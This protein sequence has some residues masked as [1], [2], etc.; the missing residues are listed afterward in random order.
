MINN[1]MMNFLHKILAFGNS[2]AFVSK[3]VQN[4]VMIYLPSF[5]EQSIETPLVILA[6]S[7]N[8]MDEL[9]R[10]FTNKQMQTPKS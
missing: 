5:I 1:I 2:E 7:I 9:M 8:L 6:W 10:T 3:R 4:D